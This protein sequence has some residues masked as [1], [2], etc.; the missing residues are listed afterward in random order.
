MRVRAMA[1]TGT[2]ASAGARR[3]QG[4]LRGAAACAGAQH[5]LCVPAT[6]SGGPGSRL[7]AGPRGA[8]ARNARAPRGTQVGLLYASR[9]HD[10]A[11]RGGT[12]AP[13]IG[14]NSQQAA[15]ASNVQTPG[16]QKITA[17]EPLALTQPRPAQ[18][19][20]AAASSRS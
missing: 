10:A 18:S 8:L 5:G 6:R 20:W 4:A 12:Q 1:A 19:A 16:W 7:N 3:Q 11:A 13:L 17:S 2:G 15:G 14:T 9:D